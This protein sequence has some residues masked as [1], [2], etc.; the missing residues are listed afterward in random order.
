M[1]GAWPVIVD[2]KA[3][4]WIEEVDSDVECMILQPHVRGLWHAAKVFVLHGACQME[5]VVRSVY[6]E[7]EVVGRTPYNHDPLL[8]VE[9]REMYRWWLLCICENVA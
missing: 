1:D 2:G 9:E 7:I 4:V 3:F 6:G 8:V 5:S